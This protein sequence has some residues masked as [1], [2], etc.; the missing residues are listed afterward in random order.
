MPDIQPKTEL[1]APPRWFWMGLIVNMIWMNISE[2]WRYF[3]FVM[4]MMRHHWAGVSDVAPMNLGIFAAWGA[5]DT[6][7]ILAANGFYW[8]FFRQFGRG[9]FAVV[10][11]ATSFWAAV[12]V[13]F[14][15]AMINMH[16]ASI[17]IVATALPLAWL[18]LVVAAVIVR[19]CITRQD[20]RGMD[21]Q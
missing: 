8:M 12:F 1:G 2:V 6:I 3:V 21:P 19:F 11:A 16:L 15:L 20:L 7:L 13:I 4:P 10:A 18:E 5:W 9:V 17:K 14:W